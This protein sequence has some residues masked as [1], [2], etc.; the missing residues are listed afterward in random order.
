MLCHAMWDCLP[1]MHGCMCWVLLAP[2]GGDGHALHVTRFFSAAL[3][4]T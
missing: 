1:M 3:H 4:V 2:G